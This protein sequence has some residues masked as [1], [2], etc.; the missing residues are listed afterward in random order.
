[1]KVQELLCRLQTRLPLH[2]AEEW[3]NSGLLL[4]FPEDP[5]RRVAVALD[6]DL[7]TLRRAVEAGANV[8]VTHHPLILSPVRQIL[9]DR[10]PGEEIAFALANGLALIALHTNWD[11]A[12]GGMNMS[13]SRTIGLRNPLPLIPSER[14]AWGTGAAGELPEILPAWQ[15]AGKIRDS[16]SLSRL[17]AYGDADRPVKRLALC[18]G[19]GGSLW[20]DALASGAQVYFTADMKYHER[21]DAC[22]SGLILFLADHGE[23]ESLSLP[24]LAEC[25]SEE[26]EERAVLLPFSPLERRVFSRDRTPQHS[27]GEKA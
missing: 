4:G 24:D 20:R 14:G 15:W 7:E 12:P 17:E 9:S 25:I 22:R 16:L 3:D 2:W 27:R 11:A 19:S 26:L 1:M 23:M 6:P 18:G 5:V 10:S 13:L 8:L 21:L